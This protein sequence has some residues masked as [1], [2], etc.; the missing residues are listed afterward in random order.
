[1]KRSDKNPSFLSK[2]G[3]EMRRSKDRPPKIRDR[4]RRLRMDFLFSPRFLEW[5]RK[6]AT[7]ISI[8]IEFGLASNYFLSCRFYRFHPDIMCIEENF[9]VTKQRGL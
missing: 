2:K 4:I 7:N 6:F 1:M 3:R 9:P 5:K 8:Y